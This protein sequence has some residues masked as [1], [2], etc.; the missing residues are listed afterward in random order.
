MK[1]K[2]KIESLEKSKW[3]SAQPHSTHAMRH[4]KVYQRMNRLRHFSFT[5]IFYAAFFFESLNGIRRV[6]WIHIVRCDLSKPLHSWDSR[7]FFFK[8]IERVPSRN[9]IMIVF[10]IHKLFRRVNK[11]VE[12]PTLNEIQR[13]K[14][15]SKRQKQLHSHDECDILGVF[16]QLYGLTNNIR[17]I[18][19]LFS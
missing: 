12:R 14:F 17:Q 10:I 3:R 18:F 9:V 6:A 7:F 4:K 15:Y 19:G 1:N 5:S 11:W 2:K 16:W 8:Y 13:A